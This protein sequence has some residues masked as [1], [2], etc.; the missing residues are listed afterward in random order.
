MLHPYI[1]AP[2][3][4]LILS[5]GLG[6]YVIQ[7]DPEDRF[8]RAFFM[9]T[10]WTFFAAVG[11]L[12]MLV[13]TDPVLA[14]RCAHIK[15]MGM[16]FVEPAVLDL[17]LAVSVWAARW[18]HPIR[19]FGIYVPTFIFIL[20]DS[21]GDITKGVQL[22]PWG[23][24]PVY[25][26]LFILWVLFWMLYIGSGVLILAMDLKDKK[27]GQ[28]Q[29]FRT[30]LIGILIPTIMNSFAEG[31]DMDLGIPT[32]L[33]SHLALILFLLF[34][35]LA[36]YRRRIFVLIPK[37]EHI[38][39]EAGRPKLDLP[40][41]HIYRLESE[42]PSVIYDFF[43]HLVISDLYGLVISRKPPNIVKEETCLIETP[44]VW[45]SSTPKNGI[46]TV[47]PSEIGQIVQIMKE[48]IKKAEGTVVLIDGL[49][50]LIFENGPKITLTALF[51]LS[52]IVATSNTRVIIPVD[53]VAI[54]PGTL[55]LIQKETTDLRTVKGFERKPIS[56]T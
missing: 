44:M 56:E 47:A 1:I 15:W 26:P 12:V 45:I 19:Q 23:Y 18:D 48:F 31:I 51:L 41:G 49:E 7:K 25:G 34:F 9:L 10:F 35:E 52:E 2:I 27:S 28:R 24:E 46:R 4:T 30:L 40:P 36:I 6:A 50:F 33:T 29:I 8:R 5:I 55:A 11:D 53:I 17:V 20:L 14:A 38:K 39:D 21:M 32:L 13:T 42:P 3:T 37:K 22:Q 54:D 16:A 43:R